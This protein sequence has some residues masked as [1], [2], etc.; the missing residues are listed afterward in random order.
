MFEDTLIQILGNSPTNTPIKQ[1]YGDV[2]EPQ[3]QRTTYI[4][5]E[6]L[7]LDISKR[8]FIDYIE[9]IIDLTTFIKANGLIFKVIKI[10]TYSDYMEIDLYQLRRQV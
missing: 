6:K 5:I 1:I 9:P 4:E 10:K 3:G 7:K 2:Q 8:L